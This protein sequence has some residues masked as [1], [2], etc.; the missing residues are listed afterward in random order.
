MEIRPVLSVSFAFFVI[1]FFN[2]MAGADLSFLDS[3]FPA[4]WKSAKLR[5]ELEATEASGKSVS[6]ELM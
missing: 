5:S 1:D 2:L 6:L 3:S 4:G